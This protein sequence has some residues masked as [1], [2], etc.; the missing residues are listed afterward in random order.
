MTTETEEEFDALE[1]FKSEIR[2]EDISVRIECISRLDLIANA[3]GPAVALSSLVPLIFECVKGVFCSDDDEVLLAFARYIPLLCRFL[4]EE[5]GPVALV[6]ILESL[7]GQDETVIREAAVKS[8]G[9]IAEECKAVCKQACLP[10]LIRLFKADWF[11]LKLSACGL[12]HFVYPQVPDESKAQ[13][14]GLYIACANDETPMVRRSAA[15]HLFEMIKVTEKPFV[16]SELIPVFEN[17][18]HDETQ[19]AV[20]SSCVAA[21]EALC[22]RLDEA[23]MTV[24][25]RDTVASLATDKSWRVRLAVVKVYGELC[26]L[27]GKASTES[28]LVEPLALLIKD[29]EPDVRKTAVIA[30][31]NTAEL[32]TPTIV[33]STFVPLFS[34]ISKDPVQQVRSALSSCIASLAKSL[35][36]DFT[37][38]HLIPLLMDSV[39][40]DH[41]TIRYMATGS[42]GTICEVVQE[43]PVISQLID[44][45]QAL[46]HDS[47]WRTRLAVLEQ[48]P[49]LS[50]LLGREVFEAKLQNLFL[51]FFGDAVHAVREALT[52]EIG[53]LVSQLGEE[54]TV[55][56]LVSK[57]TSLYS[58]TNSFSSRIA[59][60]HTL[61]K[62]ALVISR[63]E[64]INTFL[65]PTLEE[66]V[67]D[68]VPNVRF[69]ACAVARDLL[70]SS[71]TE[72]ST[73]V[74]HLQPLLDDQDSDVRYFASRAVHA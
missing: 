18:A 57:I 40:D 17:L 39:K 52:I 23:E 37:I 49:H 29:Q 9:V 58:S 7:A 41:P 20:R 35:G 36:K 68:P 72:K 16:I 13:I 10:A 25:V 15:F 5:T 60:L 74:K 42:I 56:H 59:I 45:L 22:S 38:A 70:G 26:R 19:E 43:P 62:L 66:G 47:N 48:I 33:V 69:V 24:H 51:S 27:L 31:C 64:D 1:F 73:V 14:R 63:P 12:A 2:S 46:S 21:S 30:L 3:L 54:W 28:H 61:P 71:A 55:N 6:Q 67:R 4:P 44:L 53:C 50:R 65:L 34:L 11:S 32:L 8:L